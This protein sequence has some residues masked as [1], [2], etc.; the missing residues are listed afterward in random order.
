MKESYRNAMWLSERA[1]LSPKNTEVAEVN[2][3]LLLQIPS[4]C[5]IYKSADKPCDPYVAVQYPVEF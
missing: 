1:I 2:K 3:K 5:R 4:E